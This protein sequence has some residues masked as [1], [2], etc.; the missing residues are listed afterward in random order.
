MKKILSLAMAA[1]LFC[2]SAAASFAAPLPSSCPECGGKT[3]LGTAYTPPEI[4]GSKSHCAVCATLG[5]DLSS[6]RLANVRCSECSYITLAIS[7]IE[8]SVDCGVCE[9]EP[10][11]YEKPLAE[12]IKSA[13]LLYNQKKTIFL[14]GSLFEISGHGVIADYD[15]INSLYPQLSLPKN[16]LG[17]LEF[18][19][20]TVLGGGLSSKA[21]C[22]NGQDK[23][24]TSPPENGV[25]T[26][27]TTREPIYG[28]TAVYKSPAGECVIE[29]S[30]FG[31]SGRDS[32]AF[33]PIKASDGFSLISTP[34]KYLY[35]E[36]ADARYAGFSYSKSGYDILVTFKSAA[37]KQCTEREIRGLIGAWEL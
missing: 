12:A 13:G 28:V 1:A 17:E 20:A 19:R 10:R 37:N 34:Y 3:A 31:N 33:A 24:A 2:G 4:L 21:V 30:K 23:P 5:T 15:K 8:Y 18:S 14:D 16:V 27:D 7:G 6:Y 22:F 35:D 26:V 29:A 11:Q 9:S 36:K 25:E 32:Y